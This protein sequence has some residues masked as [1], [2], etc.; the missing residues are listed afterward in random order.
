MSTANGVDA[1]ARPRHADPA[2]ADARA[3]AR[4]PGCR[5]P[6]SPPSPPAPTRRPRRCRGR[7]LPARARRRPRRR[8]DGPRPRRAAR[9]P[10]PRA[11]SRS[12]ARRSA[13]TRATRSSGTSP[14]ARGRAPRPARPASRPTVEGG[15][16]APLVYG[17]PFSRDRRLVRSGHRRGAAELRGHG[18][19]PLPRPRDRPASQRSRGRP[20]GGRQLPDGAGDTDGGNAAP[21]SRRWTSPR[22]PSSASTARRSPTSG[23]PP[24]SRR[25][26]RLGLRRL[27]PPGRSVRVRLAHLHHGLKGLGTCAARTLV[28]RRRLRRIAG[29][30]AVGRRRH[31]HRHR[32][33]A[34]L[35]ASQPLSS[36]GDPGRTFLGYIT[37]TGR[38]GGASTAPP[39]RRRGTAT[40]PTGAAVSVVD[41]TAP[42]GL[43][44]LYTLSYPVTASGT[45]TDN[46]VGTVELKGTT[47]WVTHGIPLT[48]VD[49]QI[50]LNGLT[51]TLR[52]TGMTADMRG[53]P[54]S[55]DR[56][57]VQFNLDL[58]N[59]ERRPARGR[60]AHDHRDRP[61]EHGRLRA[62]RLRGEL[63]PLR[64]D[65]P[66]ARA[67]VSVDAGL[68]DGQGRRRRS[69][70]P[71]GQGRSRR[72]R[73]RDPPQA[74]PVR[75]QE[76][77][78]RAADRPQDEQDRRKGTVEKKTLRLSVLSGTTLKGSYTLKRT[79]RQASGKLQATVSL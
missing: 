73:A 72:R 10:G 2:A 68:R 1:R 50:T 41:T 14:P 25:R 8:G 70:R 16:E 53:T 46:G 52:A 49:P 21:S 65:E 27:L 31:V 74:R 6:R 3:P 7:L 54:S 48:L 11:R 58:S 57:A 39:R 78:A 32:R 26:G 55:Y 35:D 61:G 9:K 59:G 56:T 64:H 13:G 69:R 19:L 71:G 24:S 42:R 77:G 34:R 28:T 66:D 4:V 45:Y 40:G 36:F 22:P 51:G 20:G 30:G 38:N 62:L 12:R 79:A 33:Q 44:Q 5:G 18:R 23:F 37:A 47:T 15:S 76:R 67:R 63:D 17:F 75:D 60:C 29:D 43:D